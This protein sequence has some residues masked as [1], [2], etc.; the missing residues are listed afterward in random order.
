M[1]AHKEDED[2]CHIRICLQFFVMNS[3]RPVYFFFYLFHFCIRDSHI[4][5][6]TVLFHQQDGIWSFPP[7]LKSLLNG[8]I[9][10]TQSKTKLCQ[11]L[12]KIFLG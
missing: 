2:A 9:T 12:T 10:K 8:N 1:H 6:H 7:L 3:S 5:V 11:A 4:W